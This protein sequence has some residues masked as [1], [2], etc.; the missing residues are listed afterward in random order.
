MPPFD[1]KYQSPSGVACLLLIRAIIIFTSLGIQNLNEKRKINRIV[2]VVVKGRHRESCLL[3]I[4]WMSNIKE[5]RRK[6]LP[7]W[8]H[9]LLLLLL[10][11]GKLPEHSRLQRLFCLPS[12]TPTVC[13]AVR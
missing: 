10:L 5:V 7:C 13:A 1:Y 3:T 2:L 8:A 4:T 9:L 11:Q 6:R 12:S